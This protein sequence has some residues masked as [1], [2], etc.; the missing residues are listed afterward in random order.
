MVGERGGDALAPI[1]RDARVSSPVGFGRLGIHID[2]LLLR[3]H[4]RSTP[5]DRGLSGRVAGTAH[6][7]SGGAQDLSTWGALSST[8]DGRPASA[9]AEK[10][11]RC[12][13]HA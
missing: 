5:G 1:K 8:Y 11:L 7:A 13:V 3:R 10:A 9:R 12:A 4:E 6:A 2:S